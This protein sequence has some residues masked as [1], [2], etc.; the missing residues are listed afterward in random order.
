[1][2]APGHAPHHQLAGAALLQ[3]LGPLGD[4][5]FD[6]HVD[7]VHRLLPQILLRAREL[8]GLRRIL[9]QQRRAVGLVAPAV[10]VLVDI[11]VQVE[12]RL[13]AR[14]VVLAHL[15]LQLRVVAREQRRDDALRRNRLAAAQHGDLA[16]VVVGQRDRAA[17]RHALGRVAADHRMLHAEVHQRRIDQRHAL[18]AQALLDEVGREFVVGYGDGGEF[19]GQALDHVVIAVQ[20]GQPARLRFFDDAHFDAID[21]RHAFVGE[22][23]G[24]RLRTRIAGRGLLVVGVVA[25]VRV[26]L[27]DDLGAAP[28]LGQAERPG[29]HRMLHLLANVGLHHLA[30]HRAQDRALGKGVEE[31]WRRLRQTHF[32]AVAVERAQ[33]FDLG[34]VRE[35]RLVG[36]RLLAQ[37]RQTDD[38]GVLQLEQVGAL[39]SGV[40]VAL[41][42]VD[43]VGRGQL[44]LLP[45][46]DRVIGEVDA[47]PD[48]EDEAFAVVGDLRQRDGRLRL[49]LGRPRQVVVG[50]RRF[51]DVGGHGARVQIGNLR[52]VEAGLGD[53]KCVAEHLLRC[54]RGSAA[55]RQREARGQRQQQGR[56]HGSWVRAGEACS[57]SRRQTL[58][59]HGQMRVNPRPAAPYTRASFAGL[60]RG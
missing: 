48:A 44:P 20:E 13:G 60:T 40:V 8:V 38:L 53:G 23:A 50:Q 19:V 26:A 57:L 16:L 43:V 37:L 30:R 1:M 9:Q 21:Q 11:A 58:E 42:A 34:V 45:F 14:S 46:E 22:L 17:Q 4:A 33:A 31:A 18:H 6:L 28:P 36:N 12:Q 47:R 41:D 55:T 10:A 51:E 59:R 24:N 49:D 7:R 15:G 5:E 35:R 3:L 27:E 56:F 2:R 52:R 54:L 29:A 39:E 32:E 25:V